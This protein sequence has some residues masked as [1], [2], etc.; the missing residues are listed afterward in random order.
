MTYR[1]KLIKVAVPL[2]AIN[3]GSAREPRHVRRPFE[4]ELDFGVVSVNYDPDE[5]FQH[6]A[7]PM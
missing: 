2:E 6:A 7:E 4:R 3:A 1:K 5:L